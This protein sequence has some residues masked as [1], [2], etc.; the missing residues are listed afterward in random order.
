MNFINLKKTFK[1]K[2]GALRGTIA[3]KSKKS[4]VFILITLNT[5]LGLNE[6]K[7][8]LPVTYCYATA[9]KLA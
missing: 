9:L 7:H 5:L 2:I 3:Q 8:S 4:G 6:S 1:F